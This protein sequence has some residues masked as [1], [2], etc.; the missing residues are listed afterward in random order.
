MTYEDLKILGLMRG[1]GFLMH[2]TIYSLHLL[3]MK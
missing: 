1:S 3:T 2:N